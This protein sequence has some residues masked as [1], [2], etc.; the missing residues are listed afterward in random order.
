MVEIEEGLWGMEVFECMSPRVS[1][2]FLQ[3]AQ[4]CGPGG[5]AG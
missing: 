1:Y 3:R 5:G 4:R 2:R